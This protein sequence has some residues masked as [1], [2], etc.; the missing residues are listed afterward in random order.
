MQFKKFPSTL[1]HVLQSMHMSMGM[2]GGRAGDEGLRGIGTCMRSNAGNAMLTI[3]AW[4]CG[5]ARCKMPVET[6]QGI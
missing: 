6:C 2:R 4:G 5:V 1:F 3:W